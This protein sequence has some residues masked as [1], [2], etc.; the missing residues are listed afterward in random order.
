VRLGGGLFGLNAKS[1]KD[2]YNTTLSVKAPK[3]RKEP[4]GLA[5][6]L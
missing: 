5:S 2:N 1:K 3:S 6:L 4:Q